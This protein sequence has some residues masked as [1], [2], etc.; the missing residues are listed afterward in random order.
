MAVIYPYRLSDLTATGNVPVDGAAVRGVHFNR[1]FREISAIQAALGPGDRLRG[2]YSTLKARIGAEM[3]ENGNL[4]SELLGEPDRSG[5]KLGSTVFWDSQQEAVTF[6]IPGTP[7]GDRYFVRMAYTAWDDPPVFLCAYADS[8]NG[9][10]AEAARLLVYDESEIGVSVNVRRFNGA[11]V[12]SSISGDLH[13]LAVSRETKV[14]AG[15]KA[16]GLPPIRTGS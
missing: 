10:Q 16:W 7:D 1:L 11:S 8:T 12:G 2:D 4:T 9:W 3:Q 15:N 14:W 13:W 5:N 6:S